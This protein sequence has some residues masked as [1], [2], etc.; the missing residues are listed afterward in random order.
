MDKPSSNFSWQT[1]IYGTNPIQPCFGL[2]LN[3]L[4]TIYCERILLLKYN[5]KQEGILIECKPPACLQ[6]VL[7][8]EQV[9]T[10]GAGGRGSPV[11]LKTLPSRSFIGGR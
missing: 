10:W 9:W 7:C 4:V 3:M 6:P 5:D 11:Q 8:S 1:A 2:R